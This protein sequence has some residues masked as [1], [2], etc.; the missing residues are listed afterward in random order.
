MYPVNEDNEFY[1]E[2]D[3]FVVEVK[4]VVKKQVYATSKEEAKEIIM[5]YYFDPSE[6]KNKFTVEAFLDSEYKN[7]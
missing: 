5:D 7:D 6:F 3:L 2:L 1:N 4:S